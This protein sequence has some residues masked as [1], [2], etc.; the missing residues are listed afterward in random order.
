M[1]AANTLSFVHL[2][3]IQNYQGK[4]RSV[5]IGKEQVYKQARVR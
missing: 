1:I 3:L 4:I 2:S 5:S